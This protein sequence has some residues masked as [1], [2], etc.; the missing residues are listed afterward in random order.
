[1]GKDIGR[2]RAQPSTQESLLS[3]ASS[4]LAETANAAGSALRFSMRRLRVLTLT[5][6]YPVAE[7]ES[8]GSF[9][10]EPLRAIEHQGVSNCV[11]AVYP[12]YRTGASTGVSSTSSVWR[13]YVSIPGNPGLALAG[14][15]LALS[16]A[17]HVRA[18]HAQQPFGL[19]HAHGALP[20]GRAAALLSNKLSVPFVVSVHGLDAFGERQGGPI[21]GGWC[22]RKSASVYRAARAVICISQKVSNQVAR[23]SGVNP[24]VIHNGVD[25]NCFSAAAESSPLTV[26]S[27]GNLIPIKGHELLLRAFAQARASAPGCRLEIIGDG[28]ERGRLKRLAATLGI[29]GQV[30]FL[31]R[32]SRGAVA[33]AMKG[34]AVFAL[35]S[36]FEGLGCVYLEAMSSG[37]PAIGCTGQ[38]VE[39]IIED[40]KNGLL[41][42][43]G[44]LAEL[45][46]ALRVLLVNPSLRVCLGSTARATILQ[47]HTL[48]HHAAQLVQ[49]YRECVA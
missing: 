30:R 13:R 4:V 5:P 49:L 29:S 15:F 26:L 38:G 34:C 45:I 17:R 19:I 12:F 43:P 32:Q 11:I 9:I 22:R 21:W 14:D 3:A 25:A 48:E 47:S 31:G 10:A 7:D 36:S 44:S 23:C 40:G 42:A 16:L 18:L 8:Q 41:V 2:A 35:P 28:P 37:K 24:V 6:F 1:M 33:D 46:S 39:E 27:V 20:C